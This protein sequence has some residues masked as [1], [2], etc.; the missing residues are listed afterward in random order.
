MILHQFSYHQIRDANLS[1]VDV[2]ILSELCFTGYTFKDLK[3]GMGAPN[4]I[5]MSSA[6]KK[7]FISGC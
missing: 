7:R 5:F 3:V 4:P 1:D 6:S 2:V